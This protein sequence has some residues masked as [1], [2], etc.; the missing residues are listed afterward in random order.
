[1]RT[2]IVAC[3][4]VVAFL[5]P[6]PTAQQAPIVAAAESLK[7]AVIGDNGDGSKAQFEIADRL[8]QAR[9]TFAYEFVIMLGDNVYGR[10]RTQ[11]FLDKFARPY[12]PILQAGVPFYAAIGNHDSSASL[13]YEGFNM[14]GRR[15]YT[16]ARKNVR[17]VALDTNLMEQTQIAWLDASLRESTE[18]W[19][20]AYF[21]H[22]LYSDGARHGSNE[23]LRVLLEPL[24]TRHGVRV[25]FAGHEHI[26]SRSAPQKGIVYF[27]EGSSGKLR[28]GGI[29]PTE[30]TAVSYDQDQTFMLVEVVG[31]VLSFRTIS[32]AGRIVD[33][34]VIPRRAGT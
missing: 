1:M 21:H 7:F 11:D 24:L 32:R 23:E 20:I 12:A 10:Q 6:A 9:T 15:Y 3:G 4:F 5:S 33:T 13:T 34:G 18:A 27:I 17:F 25:V 30:L 28:K 29:R 31:D 19:R 22:P 16:F 26:Y 14:G 8:T 2:L